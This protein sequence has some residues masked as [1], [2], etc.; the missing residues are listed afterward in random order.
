MLSTY[1]YPMIAL[2]QFDVSQCPWDRLKSS[3]LIK[4][5]MISL[6]IAKPQENLSPGKEA[7]LHKDGNIIIWFNRLFKNKYRGQINLGPGLCTER[8]LF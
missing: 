1:R 6:P 7:V 3:G 4:L 8:R 5:S 2:C